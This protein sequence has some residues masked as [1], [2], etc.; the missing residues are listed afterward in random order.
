MGKSL[1]ESQSFDIVSGKEFGQ[2]NRRPLAGHVPRGQR[3]HAE[4]GKDTT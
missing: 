4:D 2:G 1:K 3:L